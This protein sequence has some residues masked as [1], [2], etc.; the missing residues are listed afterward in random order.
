[1][2]LA[3]KA[4]RSPAQSP[5]PTASHRPIRTHSPSRFP[6][7]G[8]KTVAVYLLPAGSQNAAKV[9]RTGPQMH[10]QIYVNKYAWALEIKITMEFRKY[11]S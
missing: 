3:D 6:L 9:C 1:M 10:V 2:S 7:S 4:T 8:R 5:E 11:L